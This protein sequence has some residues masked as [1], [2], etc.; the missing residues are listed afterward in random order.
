MKNK[1]LMINIYNTNFNYIFIIRLYEF[2]NKINLNRYNKV[3]LI[4]NITSVNLKKNL[5]YICN[6]L[7]FHLNVN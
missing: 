7:I 3:N 5:F 2:Y 1:I 6:D 4:I